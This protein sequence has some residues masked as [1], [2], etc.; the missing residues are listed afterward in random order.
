MN[1]G[2]GDTAG[3]YSVHS[4]AEGMAR[5]TAL[6]AS[7]PELRGLAA[8]VDQ[9]GH[10]DII[11]TAEP[12]VLRNWIHALPTAR[13]ERGLFT[14]HSGAA[15]EEVLREGSLTV[16]VRPLDPTQRKGGGSDEV[17]RLGLDRLT[18]E[19]LAGGKGLPDPPCTYCGIVGGHNG[20]CPV[21]S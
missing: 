16:H 17:A 7:H 4:F 5:L 21:I 9:V 2:L 8:T 15:F 3:V 6:F 19:A 10:V 1:G 11:A 13:R 20:N 18:G 12:G 14:L